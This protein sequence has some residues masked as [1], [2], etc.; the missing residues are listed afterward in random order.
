[1]FHFEATAKEKGLSG[2]WQVKVPTVH[3]LSEVWEYIVTWQA[4]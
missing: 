3:D 2:N 1:M 4:R